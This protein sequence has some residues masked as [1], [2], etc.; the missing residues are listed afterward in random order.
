MYV[1]TYLAPRVMLLLVMLLVVVLVLG[2]GVAGWSVS[3]VVVVVLRSI[4][5]GVEL[6]SV[7]IELPLGLKRHPM[8]VEL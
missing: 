8:L 5:D 3:V 7:G 4:E 2:R 1:G 6:V